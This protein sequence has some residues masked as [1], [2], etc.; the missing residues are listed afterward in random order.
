MTIETQGR[1]GT[2]GERTDRV[3]VV[4]NGNA[5]S[6]T[7]EIVSLLDQIVLGGDL[8]VSR[9]LDE[10]AGIART[11]V[12]RGYGTVLTGGGDG[13]FVHVVSAVVREANR[14]GVRPPRFGLLRLG[15]GNA[16]AWLVGASPPGRGKGVAAD[17]AR[18]RHEAGCRPMR[19]LEVGGMLT[20]FAG[21]GMDATILHHYTRTRA[22]LSHTPLRSFAP[23]GLSYFLAVTTQSIPG[24]LLAEQPRMVVTNVGSPAF[25][26]GPDGRLVGAPVPAGG[27]IFDGPAK[28]VACSTIPTY[29]FGFRIFPYAEE[30]PDRMNLRVVN[31]SP[32]RVPYNIH[33]IW[34][35]TF[36]DPT[37]TDVLVDKIHVRCDPATPFQIGGDA[38][39]ERSEVTFAL[40]ER[41]ID[42]VD[43]YAPPHPNG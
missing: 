38:W 37:I 8:F 22:F 17:I 6:V 36:R 25:R 5:R 4:V 20:P 11:I 24:Y 27:V 26:L 14:A 29:G 21:L 32:L 43:F 23:G 33:K 18:L 2:E 12:Y 13:T 9:S 15:T 42:L 41:P 7:R 34:R 19:L 39:G 28:M 30:R 31:V 3:A 35:G 10:G 16:L 1:G 40:S